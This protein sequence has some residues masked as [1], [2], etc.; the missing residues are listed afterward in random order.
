M[1]GAIHAVS[2][3][4][5][6]KPRSRPEAFC[7]VCRDN[8]IFK[9]G[10][11]KAHHYA[12]KPDVICAATQPET[13]LHLNVKY[14]LEKQLRGADELVIQESCG[15]KCGRS[16]NIVLLKNW[17]D[18]KVEHTL[19]SFRPDITLFDKNAP[20][21]AIEVLVSQK[22]STQKASFFYSNNILGIEILGTEEIYLG[23][24][25]WT[26]DQP[27]PYLRLFPSRP[28][29]LCEHCVIDEDKRKTE[30][31]RIADQAL[32]EQKNF[33]RTVQARLVDF[34]Y[35]TGKK[36][37]EVLYLSEKYVDGKRSSAWVMNRKWQ[38]IALDI[39]P[40]DDKPYEKV[41]KAVENYLTERRE[42]GAIVDIYSGWQP[43]V[44]GRKIAPKNFDI[45]PYRYQWDVW[46]EEWSRIVPDFVPIEINPQPEIKPQPQSAPAYYKTPSW[47]KAVPCEICGEIKT[48]DQHGV[49]NGAT[50]TCICRECLNK[51]EW[52]K[53]TPR[54]IE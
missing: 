8:V 31:Q 34:Y 30:Q 4:A 11:E 21:G 13:A 1:D 37:R 39:S 52:P 49:F 23:D 27:L 5:H 16:R 47:Y 15:N 10:E 2:E 41:Y 6:L 40:E 18:V 25:R 50:Q 53:L 38:S 32:Y 12:H 9:L 42:Q 14:Y 19:G 24:Q 33:E 51:K 7:P 26:P 48:S 22:V 28:R 46:R 45:Y 17:N 36:Y 29:W 3:F 20:V 43:W 35:K 44:P 54:S